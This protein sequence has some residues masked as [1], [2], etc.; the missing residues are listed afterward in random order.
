[1]KG[2]LR[3]EQVQIKEGISCP[4]SLYVH[5][6]QGDEVAEKLGVDADRDIH[7]ID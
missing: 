3:W 5:T 7:K 1:M 6:A 4:P 2:D